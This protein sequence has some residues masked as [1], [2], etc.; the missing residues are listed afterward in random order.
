MGAVIRQGHRAALAFGACAR[1]T[2]KPVLEYLRLKMRAT[3]KAAGH[4]RSATLG[5]A[6][7]KGDG[8]EALQL[9]P[10]AAWARHAWD[11]TEL[12]KTMQRAWGKQWAMLREL[13]EAGQLQLAWD[14]VRGPAGATILTV[15]ELGWKMPSPWVVQAGKEE[16]SIL[17]LAPV[18]LL[19]MATTSMAERRLHS[20]AEA[21]EERKELR[22]RPWMP[23]VQKLMRTKGKGNWTR[24]HVNA[25]RCAVLGAYP[26]Q[27]DLYQRG[28]A[29]E[30]T[31][32]LCGAADGTNEHIMYSCQ[33][34]QCVAAREALEEEDK[35]A[36]AEVLDEMGRGAAN[37]WLTTRG[38]MPD[39]TVGLGTFVPQEVV[40]VSGPHDVLE[41]LAAT[42]G[43]LI[44]VNLGCEALKVGGWAAVAQGGAGIY[45][46]LPLPRP[47]VLAAEIWAV[48]ML[49]RHSSQLT[50]V[51]IDN[52]NVVAGLRAGRQYCCG[53]QRPWAHLWVMV[54]NQLEDHG[55]VPD[56]EFI[57]RKIKAHR[58]KKEKECM[59][60]DEL[61]R[62]E[63][64]EHAD[65]LA[66][67]VAGA[68]G[69]PQDI[70][71]KVR[72]RCC[73]VPGPAGSSR[74]S[75]WASRE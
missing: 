17:D 39:P 26:Q 56:R 70:V 46:P 5:A 44:N 22:P 47:A 67:G 73:G 18:Q 71:N 69:P 31:C 75:G 23:P 11:W 61:M 38:L 8:T 34:E 6:L 16:I 55:W 74:A 35:E 59:D 29:E 27:V 68:Y 3:G 7:T 40:L 32:P 2:P 45:G 65:L 72:R 48:L 10:L 4:F 64:N 14:L 54:W 15:A 20:W 66:K 30:P 37:A 53:S 43:S 9:A 28:R 42:D 63:L 57:V 62:V 49:L 50:E 1:G 19:E 21:K 36:L 41:G 52:A 51:L 13:V 60:D 12:K 33:A 25:L 58:T 24:R